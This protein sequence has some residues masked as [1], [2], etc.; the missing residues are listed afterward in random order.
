MLKI[1]FIRFCLVGG[2]G[3]L[4]NSVFLIFLHGKLNVNIVPAQI[5]GGEAG[6]LSNFFW[7]NT[8][9]YKHQDHQ[10]IPFWHK[11]G[12]FHLSSWSGIVLLTTIVTTG[13]NLFKLNYMVS[14]VVAAAVTMGWNFYWTKVYIFKGHTPAV[15]REPEK[16]IGT[17]QD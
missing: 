9:T 4:V 13:T 8:W 15:L 14:L 7:H 17:D 3:F 2:M 11:F 16:T 5:I 12:R 6:L 10:R 1:D